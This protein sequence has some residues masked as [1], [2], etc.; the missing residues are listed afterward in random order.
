MGRPRIPPG[1]GASGWKGSHEEALAY[2]RVMEL[3]LESPEAPREE[4]PGPGLRLI[5]SLREHRERRER[6]EES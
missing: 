3:S 6:S 4:R 5:R 1:A 2:R